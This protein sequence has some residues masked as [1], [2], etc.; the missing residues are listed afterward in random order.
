MKTQTQPSPPKLARKFLLFFLRDDLAEE[1]SG[2][3]EEKFYAI[4]KNKSP[5]RAKLNYWYEVLNYVRP[6]AFRKSR[7]YYLTHHA[8]LGN[9][10]KIGWRNLLKNRGYSFINIGGLAMGMSV[11]V[12]IGLWVHDEFSFNKY[13]RNYDRI[14]QVMKSGLHEG[15]P[16]SGGLSLQYPLIEELK[17]NY[18]H[19]F[20]FLVEASFPADYILTSGETKISRKGQFVGAGVA[21]MLSLEMIA[22]DW[23]CL[24]DPHSILLS[25]SAAKALFGDADP[26]G[27]LVNRDLKVTGV[28]KDPPHNTNFHGIKFFAP[29][30]LNLIHN[31]WIREQ[32]WDN[33]F[34]RLY[35]VIAPNTTFEKVNE[36][37]AEAE[38]RVIRHVDNMK[39][40]MAQKPR[41][42]L[43]P[44]SDWHLFADYSRW[45]NYGIPD[46][47][48]LR[49]VILIATIGGFV[50]LLACINFMNLSTARS[51]KRAREVGIRKSMGSLRRQLIN[52]F[53]LESY[54]VVVFSFLLA[55]ALA[56]IALP[57]FNSLAG[58]QMTMLWTSP[59]FW[60]GSLTFILITGLLA[61]SYPALYLSSFSPVKVLKGTIRTGRLSSIPRQVLVV[62]QFTVS[63]TLII[64]TIIVYNQ[65]VFAKQR[66]VGYTREGLIMVQKRSDDFHGKTAILREEL[67][68]TGV[69]DEIAESGGQ[70]TNVWSGNRGFSWRGKD[71]KIDP[72]FGTLGVT[73]EYGRTVGWQ[74]IDGRDFSTEMISDSSGVVINES[75]AR[76]IGLEHP[77]GE[78]V[79]WKN[80][81]WKL[82]KDFVIIGVIKDMVMES[83][84][85]PTEPTVFLLEG[86]HS[87]FNIRISPGVNAGDA[88]PKIEEV[89]NKVIPTAPFEYEFADQEYALK[90]AA[91]ERIGK[92]SSVFS[93]LAILISCLGLFGLAS[94]VAERRTKELGI[95]K[96]LGASI[97]ELWRL[98]SRDFV[99]LVLVAC[100]IAVPISLYFMSDWLTQFEYRTDISW[101]TF[102]WV[103]LGAVM[104]TLLTVSYQA[105]KAAVTNPVDSLRSE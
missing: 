37:I 66:P 38:L 33:H 59:W 4:A 9:Y 46:S 85:K 52:Q 21:E 71:P 10:V 98:L 69:V 12:L 55:I 50:L 97:L 23:N 75:A 101:E 19:N 60:C 100:C 39:E 80:K 14:A 20:K 96:V 18:A 95:R 102:A 65:I 40:Q 77:V 70:V 90:F 6:F 56:S 89:F 2:D 67:K 84:Y 32:A 103:I 47:G 105:L 48:P 41:I 94:F 57:G 29:W 104:I 36:N 82:D 99:V 8:M 13:H 22:G 3:L 34:L 92:L 16:W 86:W 53:F 45:P 15:V 1:V 72:Q 51:E 68:K 25:A 44:M 93:G 78:T 26:M 76:V 81:W 54:L 64:S 83:P 42:S 79:H 49:L 11:A 35:C 87:Y 73:S 24:Q 62:V 31:P 5:F 88:L 91:E 74:F 58:K 43:L 63:V 7:P 17:A 28:Y 61:G 27:Q 30:E